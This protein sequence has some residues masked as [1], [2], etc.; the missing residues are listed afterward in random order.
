MRNTQAKNTPKRRFD[1][2]CRL[3]NLTE[4]AIPKDENTEKISTRRVR[5][6]PVRHR[7][8]DERELWERV[9]SEAT[10]K[11]PT[12]GL[13]AIV[14]AIMWATGKDRDKAGRC[15]REIRKQHHR[16]K[17]VIKHTFKNFN[18]D[19]PMYAADWATCRSVVLIA[20]QGARLPMH[21]KERKYEL[22]RASEL[23]KT[24]QYVECESIDTIQRV[25]HKHKSVKQ[26][27]FGKYRVDLY[28]PEAK[29][30]VECDEEQ[31]R[32]QGCE[33]SCRQEYIESNFGVRFLRYKTYDESFCLPR[34]IVAIMEL[35]AQPG[36]PSS[37]HNQ[38]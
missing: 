32:W 17:F 36:H 12:M 3:S 22:L 11:H 15:F 4:C 16:F 35:L 33:D 23:E 37:D 10:V 25:F 7:M 8:W 31:H 21:D 13:Y 14:P 6:D 38:Q 2:D 34:V 26:Q 29:L 20:L 18:D 27:I 30:C 5:V 28:F 1:T 19:Q 9:A 24:R